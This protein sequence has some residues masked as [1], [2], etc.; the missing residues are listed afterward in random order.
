MAEQK[1]A[2]VTAA[3]QGM[4]KATAEELASRGYKL[5]LM[6]PSNRSVDLAKKL[7]GVGMSGSVL[8][9]KD[10]KAVVQLAMNTYGRIDALVNNT[11]NMQGLIVPSTKVRAEKA[12]DPDFD[13]ILLDV[14]DDQ[15]HAALDFYFLNVVRMCRAVTPIM[16]KQK[17]GAIANISSLSALE[18]RLTYAAGSTI[19]MATL[20]FTKLY[21][22]RYG[23][24]GIRINSVLP[25]FMDNRVFSD[26]VVK[27][28]PLSRRG[29][30]E[31][32]A[33]TVAFL[34]S[35]D[36]GYITGQ[37]VLVDGGVNRRM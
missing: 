3:G 18:P 17:K 12:Y 19:R 32:V 26:E 2:L 29:K 14:P 37:N 33:K 7:G 11:G 10:I 22:D 15:W 31:E 27:S 35:D 9:T 6:S 20:T 5:V 25:G 24:D 36:A 34:V 28:V 21:A 23:R 30:I 8:E 1:V 13:G 16:V 4:G